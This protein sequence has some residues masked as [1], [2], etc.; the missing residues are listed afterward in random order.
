VFPIS[1]SRVSQSRFRAW[2]GTGASMHPAAPVGHCWPPTRWTFARRGAAPWSS[3]G[4]SRR[5]A[6]F[7]P[8]PPLCMGFIVGLFCHPHPSPVIR[9]VYGSDDGLAAAMNV[10]V[11]DG[12]FLL[13]LAPIRLERFHLRSERSQQPIGRVCEQLYASK[14]STSA[15][16]CL[17]PAHRRS[18]NSVRCSSATCKASCTSCSTRD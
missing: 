14:D 9:V 4:I 17:S 5:V 3:T 11:F 7:Q 12:Y 1:P 6:V 18:R 15:R 16:R 13:S 10:H 8:S 2:S